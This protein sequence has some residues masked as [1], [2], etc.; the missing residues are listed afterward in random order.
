MSPLH[1][2][3]LDV[4]PLRLF[5]EELVCTV[6]RFMHV[7]QDAVEPQAVRIRQEVPLGGDDA[8]ADIVVSV[9]GKKSYVVE[10][11]SGYPPDRILQALARKYSGN[12]SWDV[13]VSRMICIVDHFADADLRRL[14][15]EIRSLIPRHLSLELW[16]ERELL[17]LVHRYFG[18][19]I[20]SLDLDRIQDVRDAIDRAKG[21]YAF[22]EAQDHSALES[23]LLWHFGYWR[24]RE[25]F[26]QAGR[27]KRK[28]LTP[29]NYPAVA[30]VFADLSGFSGYVRDTQDHRTIE[31]CLTAFCSR[32]R[33]QIINDG[34]MLYQFLGDA[35][36][37]L[38]GI[39]SHRA[40]YVDHAFECARALLSVA[41]SISNEWQRQLDRVQPAS[42]CHIGIA[43]GTI[44]ILSLRP[45]SR[46][47]IGVVS[48]A[49][50]MA[51]RL[52]SAARPG[53]I[54]LSN[55]LHRELSGDAKAMLQE[56]PPVE[57]KNVGT[58]KAWVYESPH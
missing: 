13:P 23:S 2:R 42:G 38:F 53:Q 41:A 56:A 34:G 10:V 35:V 39:P 19:E 49:I 43:L 20:E 54:V 3:P 57:A 8:F 11:K 40:G 58:I 12:V 5:V 16:D 47:H 9:P 45:F 29:G 24:L 36:I 6:C 32:S 48:D 31:D 33:Y 15:A 50:N 17:R 55:L 7:E 28:V 27:A 21:Q 44:Q 18:V 1:P 22:G 46:T 30:C 14:E 26:D 4:V 37:G 25:L 52:C 51:A